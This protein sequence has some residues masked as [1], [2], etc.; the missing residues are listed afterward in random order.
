MTERRRLHGHGICAFP[1]RSHA[2][3]S[4][5][6]QLAMGY[7][8]YFEKVSELF[9][10][11]GRSSSIKQDLVFLFPN[12]Q[13]LQQFL[14]EYLIVIV[15]FCRGI[16]LYTR[17]AFFAQLV[18][19]FSKEFQTFE[20]DLATW[21]SIIQD[22]AN[23]LTT[24]TQLRS[25]RGIVAT[26]YTLS[27]FTGSQARKR[28]IDERLFRLQTYISPHQQ[29]FDVIW[30]RERKKGTTP[31]V[32][33]TDSYQTWAK[34][35]E[36]SVLHVTGSL[37]S[38]KTVLLANV[39]AT[40][41]S[42]DATTSS[43]TE[44]KPVTA[45]FFC[46]FGNAKSLESRH[47]VGSLAYQFVKLLVVEPSVAEILAAKTPGDISDLDMDELVD[48]VVSILPRDR[49][50]CVV[51]DALDECSAQNVEE[52]V[53]AISKL[54]RSCRLHLCFSTRT[55]SRTSGIVSAHFE[56]Q[57][58]I[59][60]N[61]AGRYEELE[62][63]IDHEIDR[64]QALR[65]L[66]PVLSKAIKQF[67]FSNANGMYLWVILQ[68]EALFPRYGGQRIL[69][70]AD[71]RDM[72][73][74]L[75][76]DLPQA[77]D[78][79]LCG[80]VDDRY[81]SRVFEI[82]GSARRPLTLDEFC[83]A[84]NVEPG[85]VKWD[86]ATFPYDAH[87]L[88]YL[89]GGGL[90]EV[91]EEDL[92][93][94]YI[95]S[96]VLKYLSTPPKAEMTRGTG[97]FRFSLTTAEMKMGYICVT[98][99]S[100]DA[101]ETQLTRAGDAVV[102]M[103]HVSASVSSVV[104][105]EAIKGDPILGAV[106]NVA[107]WLRPAGHE[108]RDIDIVQLIQQCSS[109]RKTKSDPD[110]RA[111]LAYARENWLSHS[112]E[113]L[114]EEELPRFQ[115]MLKRLLNKAQSSLELPWKPGDHADALSWAIRERHLEIFR[116]LIAFQPIQP[117]MTSSVARF[118]A[119]WPQ[120]VKITGELL[121]DIVAQTMLC[122]AEVAHEERL[123]IVEK[124]IS[125]GADPKIPCVDTSSDQC[126]RTPLDMCFRLP[127]LGRYDRLEWIEVLL[128]AGADPD[129]SLNASG[130][131][132]AILHA[133]VTGNLS[134]LKLL[135]E[136]GANANI[137]WNRDLLRLNLPTSAL[138]DLADLANLA[139][140]ADLDV[141]RPMTMSPLALIV[142]TWEDY[143]SWG[144]PLQSA[145]V[146]GYD[147]GDDLDFAKVLLEAGADPNGAYVNDRSPVQYLATCHRA[148]EILQ[149]LIESGARLASE[150]AETS[151]L[152][153]ALGAGLV[154]NATAMLQLSSEGNQIP[155]R[156]LTEALFVFME[157]CPSLRSPEP[158]MECLEKLLELGANVNATIAAKGWFARPLIIL[159]KTL[160]HMLTND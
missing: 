30:R 99:L 3:S 119:G 36:S 76:A 152:V 160:P 64:R 131:G 91:D 135:L 32:F 154:E 45:C 120:S 132:S 97:I 10:R 92:T 6:N 67:L 58:K 100:Y 29:E 40:T 80:I 130:P 8:S 17:K 53:V 112:K 20:A 110:V 59:S 28:E 66:N 81:G 4:I 147:P 96:S 42:Q 49:S 155:R 55:E 123:G 47:I 51:L 9:M 113:F 157:L 23:Y 89:S 144:R 149:L 143:I 115:S 151:P 33:S 136:H 46:N 72:L 74:H 106:V 95:H 62:T 5:I 15:N 44:G 104:E 7:L 122:L 35:S 25:E 129:C 12:C 94:T 90:L 146:D 21:S 158:S 54:L 156:D 31:W 11:L 133:L 88:V 138:A 85:N 121:G 126:G 105:Q 63:Y 19:S 37:G 34:S 84:L 75:P 108:Y 14:C 79:A 137:S 134:G 101:F 139:D 107:K 125:H 124:M 61:S 93:V 1:R 16:V 69:C 18:V 27:L 142:V 153:L 127:D 82:V 78:R 148:V 52:V 24:R 141:L 109:T 65:P 159:P 150:S 128:R 140:L 71:I 111:F 13:Q 26:N 117:S 98:Y 48:F 86:E 60:M 39:F 50:Y 56:V 102:G 70:D 2:N 118:I 77:F 103:D 145:A 68:I 87:S 43:P 57:H 73:E 116:C 83:V 38:G 22:R 114:V 41:L